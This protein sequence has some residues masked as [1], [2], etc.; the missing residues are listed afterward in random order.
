ME[1]GNGFFGLQ[2]AND[3]FK[4]L[5]EDYQH[6]KD[7]P[8]NS[9]REFNFFVMAGHLPNWIFKTE[10]KKLTFR[11]EH[12]IPRICLD[13]ANG[14]KHFG[15]SRNKDKFVESTFRVPVREEGVLEKEIC[16]NSLI[17]E[18]TDEGKSEDVLSLADKVMKFWD[19]HS[20]YSLTNE[21]TSNC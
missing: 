21:I 9:R 6:L 1:K 17:V 10:E 4:K 19:E 3:L 16:D 13:L 8:W 15:E 5:K 18:L 7:S 2:T 11:N 14:A 20:S 12:S